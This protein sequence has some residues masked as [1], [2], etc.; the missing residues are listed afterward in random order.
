[1]EKISP[2]VL[3]S[4]RNCSFNDELKLPQ[5]NDLIDRHLEMVNAP[6]L[7]REEAEKNLPELFLLIDRIRMKAWFLPCTYFKLPR[8]FLYIKF[9]APSL[10]SSNSRNCTINNILVFLIRDLLTEYAY[11]GELAGLFYTLK[12]TKYGIELSVRGYSAKQHLYLSKILSTFYAYKTIFAKD[13]FEQIQELHRKGIESSEAEPLKNQA[14]YLLSYILCPK[15]FHR[16]D[17]LQQLSTVKFEDVLLYVDK[18]LLQHSVECFFFGN[19]TM[20]QAEKLANV[21]IDCRKNYLED[22]V[23]TEK[24]KVKIDPYL[25]EWFLKNPIERIVLLENTL[26]KEDTSH[27][28]NVKKNL[29]EVA[30]ASIDLSEAQSNN[31]NVT[32]GAASHIRE[33]NDMNHFQES[34][35]LIN[36]FGD[37]LSTIEEE[38]G[39]NYMYSTTADENVDDQGKTTENIAFDNPAKNEFILPRSK[40]RQNLFIIH[41][42]IQSSSCVL[43]YLQYTQNL[44]KYAAILETFHQIIREH[45]ISSMR[46]MEALGYVVSCD[47]RRGNSNA[48]IGLRIIVESHYPLAVVHSRIEESLLNLNDFL[49]D[50]TEEAFEM[51][52]S[53]LVIEK[54]ENWNNRMIDRAVTIWREVADETYNFKRRQLEIGHIENISLDQVRMF[55]KEWVHPEGD[56]RRHLTISIGPDPMLNKLDIMLEGSGEHQVR[57]W[58]LREINI[59]R[60]DAESFPQISPEVLQSWYQQVFDSE[61]NIYDA[62][63]SMIT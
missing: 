34:E 37:Q 4:W 46:Y 41:N 36:G 62:P 31:R 6:K 63:N 59:Y 29:K 23:N 57:H 30:E 50:M 44:P 42:E 15:T 25:E 8:T 26:K 24:L 49:H 47:I 52:K 2:T 39:N 55:Y 43:F 1:M 53:A 32:E 5:P 40:N 14:K 33:E 61:D 48:T 35:P 17:R 58:D 22:R 7:T 45:L 20:P 9:S 12:P 10:V 18:F 51:G 21:V 16:S 54:K 56:E 11:C 27:W 3:S 28:G 60:K 13:R 19:L 38:K